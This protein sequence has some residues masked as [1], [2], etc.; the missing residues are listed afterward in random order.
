M[1]WGCDVDINNKQTRV[2]IIF[3]VRLKKGGIK[4]QM[5]DIV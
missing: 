3:F 1:A 2:D 4:P 5:N